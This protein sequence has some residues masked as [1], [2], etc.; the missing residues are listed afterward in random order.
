[1]TISFRIVVNA[2]TLDALA[3]NAPQIDGSLADLGA[4]A[5]LT[6]AQSNAPVRTGRLRGSITKTVVA[7]WFIV[8]A[9]APYSGFIE[10][11]TRFM[12]AEPFMTP[13]AES[14]DWPALAAAALH[15]IGL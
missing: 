9:L 10:W 4:D 11:G 7:G 2:H 13:A 6:A 1:M 8:A 5:I 3:A 12:A 14:V 15:Q